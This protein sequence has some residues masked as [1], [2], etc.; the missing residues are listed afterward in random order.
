MALRLPGMRR[1]DRLR[2]AARTL[3]YPLDAIVFESTE[4]VAVRNMGN[5][6]R[7]IEHLAAYPP[8]ALTR[9]RRT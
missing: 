5:A 4:Q 6:A 1:T 2:A 9:T 3:G 8:V 7:R